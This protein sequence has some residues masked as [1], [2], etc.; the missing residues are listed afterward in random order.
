MHF[1]LGLY[2]HQSA[3]A[4]QGILNLLHQDYKNLL[5]DGTVDNFETIKITSYEPAFSIIG[6]PDKRN[7]ETRQSADHSMVYIVSALLKK[8]I[9]KQEM[10]SECKDLNDFWKTLMLNPIDYSKHMLHDET[11]RKLMSKIEFKHGGVEYDSKYPEGIPTSVEIKTKDGKVFDSGMVLFPGGHA[12]CQDVEVREVLRHKFKV[13]GKLAL[14]KQQTIRLKISLDNIQ[15]MSNEELQDI[16]DCQIKFAEE[17]IDELEYDASK[18][19]KGL[20][21]MAR[22]MLSKHQYQYINHLEKSTASSEA[23]SK[24]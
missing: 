7:P 10:L 5:G 18:A 9:R 4:I 6:D 17:P 11:I 8:V 22:A 16:Y 3:G 12:N 1:K 21:E 23:S 14:E 24:A 13:L 19:P 20:A 2:E 15:D